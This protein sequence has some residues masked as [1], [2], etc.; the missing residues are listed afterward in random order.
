MKIRFRIDLESDS[1]YLISIIGLFTMTMKYIGTSCKIRDVLTNIFDSDTSISTHGM[2]IYSDLHETLFANASFTYIYW[3][4]DI[5][6]ISTLFSLLLS[7]YDNVLHHCLADNRKLH[8]RAIGRECKY[9][10]FHEWDSNNRNHRLV[11]RVYNER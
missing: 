11:D 6:W 2:R 1:I 10:C 4:L 5:D 3:L 8:R 9:R 7:I